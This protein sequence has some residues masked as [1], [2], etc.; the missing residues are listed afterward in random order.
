MLTKDTFLDAMAGKNA[1]VKFF[2]P[3][4]GHCKAMK[5]AWD[6]LAKKYEGHAKV[7]IY[8]VDCT[9]ENDLCGFPTIKSFTDG[10]AEAYESGRDLD[11]LTKH[12]EENLM[13]VCTVTDQSEC[14]E[15]Q[16]K[17]MNEFLS[18]TA[19]DLDKDVKDAEAAVAKAEE[20][21]KNTHEK[22]RKMW[23][24]TRDKMQK[25]MEPLEGIK[26][27]AQKKVTTIKKVK[28]AKEAG[29]GKG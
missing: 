20:D 21:L 4:C 17:E 28:K 25:E 23:E 10:E 16:K 22:Y 6:D 3:W 13:T 19:A 5:P 11:S 24:E 26:K 12:V 2:A 27:A 9:V 18:K 7:G 8:D 15:E 29:A 14:T 1:F